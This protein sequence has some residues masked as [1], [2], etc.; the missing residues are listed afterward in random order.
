MIQIFCESRGEMKAMSVRLLFLQNSK[1]HTV[2]VSETFVIWTLNDAAEPSLASTLQL[3]GP[4]TGTGC[5][6]GF[7]RRTGSR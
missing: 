1:Q 7:H 6:N 4:E 3:L 5:G 2:Y